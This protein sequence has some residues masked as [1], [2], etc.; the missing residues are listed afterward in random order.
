MIDGSRPLFWIVYVCYEADRLSLGVVVSE[1]FDILAR[2][3]YSYFFYQLRMLSA[4]G[5]RVLPA[6]MQPDRC[7]IYFFEE[8]W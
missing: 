6:R 1:S 8:T 5:A 2:L 3:T 4:L 7:G